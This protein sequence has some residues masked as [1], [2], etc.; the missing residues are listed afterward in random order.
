VLLNR[1]GVGTGVPVGSTGS[2]FTVTFATGSPNIHFNLGNGNNATGDFSPDGR[3]TNPL[4]PTP[5]EFDTA[6]TSAA[7][8]GTMA[9]LDPNGEWTLF[10]ADVNSNDGPSTSTVVSWSLELEPV[11]EPI[12]IALGV[13]GGLFLIVGVC[14]SERVKRLF[15]NRAPVAA[16]V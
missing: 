1:V 2:G 11:P 5:S 3:T 14:R 7:D 4:T 10:F 15:G 6:D 16:I 8:F 12:N 9:G 13:F